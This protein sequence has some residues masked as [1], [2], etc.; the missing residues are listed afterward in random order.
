MPVRE[1][2]VLKRYFRA[3]NKP[4]QIW[5]NNFFD[6]LA[7]IERQALIAYEINGPIIYAS[8]QAH[9]LV[10]GTAVTVGRMVQEMDTGI[11]FVKQQQPGSNL[12]DWEAIGDAQITIPDV[13]DLQLELDNLYVKDANSAGNVLI[14]A[15][16]FHQP[17]PVAELFAVD[18]GATERVDVDLTTGNSMVYASV[19]KNFT[20]GIA[21]SGVI[22]QGLTQTLMAFNSSGG[23]LEFSMPADTGMAW[24]VLINGTEPVVV[25]SGKFL[26]LAIQ[27]LPVNASDPDYAGPGHMVYFVTYGLQT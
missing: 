10:I 21:A 14:G 19:T 13:E 16:N 5:W 26:T 3:G 22:T 2:E 17:G 15:Y 7:E 27:A 11:T 1:I 24:Y 20:L 4:S 12:G 25:A 23:P 9:R 6:S 18:L 8:N